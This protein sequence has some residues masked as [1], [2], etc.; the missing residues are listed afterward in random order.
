[1]NLTDAP[2]TPAP[3]FAYRAFK[4]AVL[5]TP[6]EDKELTIPIKSLNT[7]YQRSDGLLKKLEKAK[8]EDKT[9]A[10]PQETLPPPR[11]PTHVPSPTKSILL[12]PGTVTARRKTVSFGEGVVDNERKRTTFETSPKKNVLTGNIS[13]QWPAPT[14]D[15]TKRNR[16]K[17][18]QEMFNIREGKSTGNDDLFNIAETKKPT[19]AEKPVETVADIPKHSL[20]Q[21]EDDGTTN[22]N[23][24]H[25]QSG[26]YWKS[27]YESY[28]AKS[29]REIKKLI[30]YRSL[31]KS[32]AKKK[33]DEVL[34]LTDRLKQEEGRVREMEQCLT[35]LAAGVAEKIS[36][37]EPGNEAMV[38][39]LSQQTMLTLKHKHKT[40]SLR[41][42]LERNGILESDESS[43]EDDME[44]S[45][46]AAKL[47]AVQGE[48]DRAN[49]QL[50]AQ[51]QSNDLKK[52]QDLA[53]ASERKATEL[54]KENL[55]LKRELARVK[56]EISGYED[57]RKAKEAK[58]KQRQ[59]TLRSRVEEYSKQLRDSSKAH[60]EAEDALRK[61]FETEKKELQDTIDTLKHRLALLEKGIQS[62]EYVVTDSRGNKRASS[63]AR[64]SVVD[65]SHERKVKAS[66]GH[67]LDSTSKTVNA[68]GRG[69]SPRRN[70]SKQHGGDV[71][72]QPSRNRRS[73][74][75]EPHDRTD[76]GILSDLTDFT[77][78][79]NTTIRRLQNNRD[80]LASAKLRTQ[81]S[82]SVS[83]KK[84]AVQDH[85]LSP[86]PSMVYMEIDPDMKIPNL[87][88]HQFKGVES[89]LSRQTVS[90]PSGLNRQM[91]LAPENPARAS[92][93]E[94][95]L[96][97]LSPERIA[98]SKA[99]IRAEEAK[100][101]GRP[102]GKENVYT[103]A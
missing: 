20:Q 39:E 94:T 19:A 80:L 5:G 14:S 79:P 100:R 16:S 40:A 11:E 98:A 54:D 18:T 4:N 51:D 2:E 26:K 90:T 7:S 95:K 10:Q 29:D 64:K 43:H 17:L 96:K 38:K 71:E 77:S 82:R 66:H 30:E 49:A 21:P 101:K 99:R 27:E 60:H 37:G 92:S 6:A 1:M 23:E 15:P 47:R 42:A 22:L 67:D 57:R 3:V 59:E 89:R 68:T 28:R 48:L 34:R 91:S 35:K 85:H 75:D 61:T 62:K 33:E 93:A 69:R 63:H 58:L 86:R 97:A 45:A 88:P 50:R 32:F 78:T 52:L 8:M 25:S 72:L 84:T 24:P 46:V 56:Q 9:A 73:S 102:R 70:P 65:P 55:S 41:R 103:S 31:T 13:R 12:T 76:T 81:R 53:E 83:P 74:N 36:T 44:E 87:R